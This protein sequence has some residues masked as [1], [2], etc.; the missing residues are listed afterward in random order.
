VY[1]GG[2]GLLVLLAEWQVIAFLPSVR[3]LALLL[4][5]GEARALLLLGI[6]GS[7]EPAC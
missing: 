6:V 5:G 1:L 3:N 7:I 2:T 4:F